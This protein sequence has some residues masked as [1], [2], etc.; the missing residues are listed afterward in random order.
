MNRSQAQRIALQV[1]RTDVRQGGLDHYEPLVCRGD[2]GYHVKVYRYGN[3]VTELDDESD[4]DSF[5][6]GHVAA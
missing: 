5:L 1:R 6:A 4:R 2:V 3:L